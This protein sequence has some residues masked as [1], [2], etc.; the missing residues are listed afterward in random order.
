VFN[1]TVSVGHWKPSSWRRSGRF[2]EQG[3]VGPRL[4]VFRVLEMIGKNESLVPVWPAARGA[5]RV[6]L[7]Q[8]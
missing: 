8:D 4:S 6:L 2:M 3:R 7:R 5:E 1:L